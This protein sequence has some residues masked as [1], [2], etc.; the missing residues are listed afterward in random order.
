MPGRI[1]P[2]P[3]PLLCCLAENGDDADV[4]V[5]V[6]FAAVLG[7][8]A[9]DGP[10]FGNRMQAAGFHPTAVFGKL[11]AAAAAAALLGCD[12]NQA[13]H[14]LATA[15]TFGGGLTASFGSMAKPLHSG[16][17]AMD[18]IQAA[19]LAKQ[20][21]V[22]ARDVFEAPGGFAAAFVQTAPIPFDDVAFTAGASL[23]DNSFKPYACGKLI[24][25]HID[26]ARALREQCAG[27]PIKAIRCKAPPISA[28]LV[29]RPLPTTHLEGK[30]SIAFCV[31]A[32]L[33]GYPLLPGDF[34]D[35][36]LADPIVRDLMGKV[37]VSVDAAMGRYGSRLDIDLATGETLSMT[38]A[39]S[40]GNPENPLSWEYLKAKF[41]G[42]VEPVLGKDT[43]ALYDA[44]RTFEAPGAFGQILA[45]VAPG[46]R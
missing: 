36:R 9:T 12:A 38:V 44:I 10:N 41:D 37:V 7:D 15:A 33:A 23:A 27:R 20:G 1:V 11:S 46:P 24:H 4:V 35:D 45:I 42:L 22:A 13:A 21:L 31:A 18:G 26:A 17:A 16:K 43:D 32:A 28:R 6:P 2:S 34:S 5:V 8:V 29:G 39:H 25:G 14:A 19:E 3:I 30:F 40:R